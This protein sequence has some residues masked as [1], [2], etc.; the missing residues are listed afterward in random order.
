M[1]AGPLSVWVNFNAFPSHNNRN[2]ARI[3]T[4]CVLLEASIGRL[5]VI[6]QKQIQSA[7]N[8]IFR[9]CRLLARSLWDKVAVD[10]DMNLIW[11]SSVFRCFQTCWVVWLLEQD[12]SPFMS[13]PDMFFPGHWYVV[14][15][16]PWKPYFEVYWVPAMIVMDQ[17]WSNQTCYLLRK[18]GHD[19]HGILNI[20]DASKNA[21]FFHMRN[22]CRDVLWFI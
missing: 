10:R 16:F 5:G 14:S 6:L 13:H 17:S 7:L 22:A 18:S 15:D 4:T 9:S 8:N 2:I 11:T 21:P 20:N 19:K 12:A 3:D 1:L